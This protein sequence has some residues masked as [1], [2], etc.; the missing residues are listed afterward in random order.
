MNKILAYIGLTVILPSTVLILNLSSK[1]VFLN[2]LIFKEYVALAGDRDPEP[3]GS[4][5]QDAYTITVSSINQQTV[6]G[7][8]GG[9]PW[10]FGN[11]FLITNYPAGQQKI[12][13]LGVSVVRI[14]WH[15]QGNMFDEFG[16][17]T[18]KGLTIISN[19]LDE[20]RWLS[21]NNISYNLAP[22][23]N[24]LNSVECYL[25]L[26]SGPDG[27][28]HGELKQDYEG[29]LIQALL[30]VLKRIK[31]ENLPM[32]LMVT[33]FN[34]PN[35]PINQANAPVTGKMPVDQVVRIFKRMKL[36]LIKEG[37]GNIAFGFCDAGEVIYACEYLG[38]SHGSDGIHSL[39]D[40][41]W[42]F[43]NP[44]SGQ[45]DSG[46]DKAIDCF[47]YHGYYAES[48]RLPPF[49]NGYE[50]CNDGRDLWQTEYCYW[51]EDR[52]TGEAGLKRDYDSGMM[53]R[54]ISDLAYL[55]ANYWEMWIMFRNGTPPASDAMFTVDFNPP[56]YYAFQKIFKN[57]IPGATKVRRVTSNIP[58]LPDKDQQY[59]NTVAFV[60]E[61]KTIVV[62]LNGSDRTFETSVKGL[63]GE[64]AEVW[65]IKT[66]QETGLGK[67]FENN[68]RYNKPMDLINS[69]VIMNGMVRSVNLAAHTIT[70]IV[71]DGGEEILTNNV[72]FIKS[73]KEY[74]IRSAEIGHPLGRPNMP[75]PP[76]KKGF[77]FVG[78]FMKE[79][80]KGAALTSKTIVT[81]P[82]TLYACFKQD[83]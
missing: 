44:L 23:F 12:L 13:D 14:F 58:D 34:E 16:E 67:D 37:F 55:K 42:P 32:P 19:F 74:A 3:C 72:M 22:G 63:Y 64:K 47:V 1:S 45:Y 75:A 41:K 7:F 6:K 33:P 73:G 21:E 39:G 35:C 10:P 40:E 30:Y 78:W 62:I 4:N 48:N 29:S 60:S 69:S 83:K 28:P 61:E 68:P 81:K 38:N 79:N 50:E 26:G 18:T 70:V 76:D 27:R 46:L 43:V 25:Q 49:V 56:V 51:H 15:N 20:I 71:T 80:G 65:Q 52:G 82:I 31:E 66:G 53:G 17:P 5:Q 36:D 9:M 2:P 77:T 59:M 24:T 8:G 11:K 57:I 54:F